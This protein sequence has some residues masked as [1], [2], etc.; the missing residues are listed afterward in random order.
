MIVIYPATSLRSDHGVF[1]AIVYK[2]TVL[3]SIDHSEH[4]VSK[5]LAANTQAEITFHLQP[6]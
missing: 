5:V 6:I 4:R 2:V 3:L 1:S